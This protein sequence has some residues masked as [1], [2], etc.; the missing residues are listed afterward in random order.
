MEPAG[1]VKCNLTL[2]ARTVVADNG[3]SARAGG[4]VHSSRRGGCGADTVG[5]LARWRDSVELDAA[6]GKLRIGPEDGFWGSRGGLGLLEAAPCAPFEGK[7][8]H[9]R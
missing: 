1:T 9:W 2:L 5:T 4:W 7:G 3:P 6:K 8:I